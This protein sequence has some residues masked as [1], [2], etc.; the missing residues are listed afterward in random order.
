MPD[1]F[2]GWL[3][4]IETWLVLVWAFRHLAISVVFWRTP[5]LD[6]RSPRFLPVEGEAPAKVSILLP[7]KDEQENVA[8]C[9]SDLLAQNYPDFEVI[10][11][12]DRSSDGT[13]EAARKVADADSRVKVLH[14]TDRPSGWT[15]KTYA[16]TKGME[17]A[18]GQWLLFVDADTRHH[19][20]CLSICMAWAQRRQ[21]A[22]VS[23]LPKM[24]CESF[25][26]RVNQ[27][28][29]GIVLMRSFPPE[30]VNADW[31]G[32]AFANGQYIL[33]DRSVYET[34][35]GHA[36]VRDKFVEDIYLAREVKLRLKRRVLTA[37]SPEIC[38]TR[39]YNDLRSQIQGWARIYYDAWRRNVV[40]A[41]WKIAEPLIFTQPAYVMP[42]VALGF[43]A[44]GSQS[45]L[46]LRL[47]G[48]SLLHNVLMFTVIA[49]MYRF[50][51]ARWQDALWYPLSGVISDWIYLQVIR[52]CLTGQVTWR[53]TTYATTKGPNGG[54]LSDPHLHGANVGQHEAAV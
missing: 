3:V 34:T 32:M 16:L 45:Q 33:V 53:G 28:L 19:P 51:Q 47:L 35:G 9:A 38:S 23:L 29:C 5:W 44:F 40:T 24:R 22:M 49:R 6:L 26:E 13:G 39:M 37:V 18:T 31:S 50:N 21:A 10:I 46:A 43:M 14:L 8:S 20:D 36:S 30:L 1:T 15:G 27:P 48:L 2:L 4:V 42:F 41:L 12:D 52:M 7:C 17:L 11:I 25:W 54:S